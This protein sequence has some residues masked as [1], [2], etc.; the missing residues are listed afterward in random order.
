MKILSVFDE[1]FKSY[2]RV[3]TKN[4]DLTDLVRVMHATEAPS[5]A[6][7]Y[8]PSVESLE[9]LP[10]KKELEDSLFGG[11]PIQIGYCNGTNNALNAL[12]YHRSSEF[13]VSATDLILLLGKQQDITTDYT[14]DT[15]K[16]EAFFVPAG[17]LVEMYA[18]TLH[19]AP[20]SA[21]G[22]PFRNVVI[23]PKDTNTDLEVKCEKTVED[24][25]L[26]AKNKWLIAHKEAQI[27]GA[28]EGLMGEN[29]HI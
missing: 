9:E 21:E 13:G 27:G 17:E 25:L 26:V 15:S 2:G 16:V 3:L 19:Y 29:I 8:Y 10:I 4:Y 1:S 7:V 6:V 23:L 24:Q 28:Y 22:K 5:D 11:L 12:E 14:Y 18:T 20:C